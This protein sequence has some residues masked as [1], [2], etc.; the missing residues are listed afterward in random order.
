VDK[1]VVYPDV[2]HRTAFTAR[3]YSRPEAPIFGHF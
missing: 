2:E 3:G 1:T